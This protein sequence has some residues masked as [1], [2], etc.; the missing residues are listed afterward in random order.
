MSF[1]IQQNGHARQQDKITAL[2]AP[3]RADASFSAQ[4][5][6]ASC[7]S[8]KDILRF[9]FFWRPRP[10]SQR[11]SDILE[12]SVQASSNMSLYSVYSVYPQSVQYSV[13][14]TVLWSVSYIYCADGAALLCPILYT[15]YR[16]HSSSS[17]T[18]PRRSD[19]EASV[20]DGQY[21][22]R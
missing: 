16:R 15:V 17:S 11:F 7:F 14:Y 20:E 19:S 4:L 3:G 8:L 2:R 22:Y 13:S 6:D 18:R 5:L 10:S 21:P 1:P 12:S 9:N